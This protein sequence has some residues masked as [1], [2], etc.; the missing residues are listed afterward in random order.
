MSDPL[1]QKKIKI[2]TGAGCSAW[3]AKAVV[4][5]LETV[6][7]QLEM[8]GFDIDLT[9]CMNRCGG[10]VSLGFP[11]CQQVFKL[12]E[13]EKTLDYVFQGQMAFALAKNC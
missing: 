10:G 11:S 13:P 2:C 6:R 1:P 3:S 12:K 8:E 5:E 9:Q 7:E 4:K